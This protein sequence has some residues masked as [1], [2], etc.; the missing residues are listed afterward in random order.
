MKR[1]VSII[2]EEKYFNKFCVKMNRIFGCKEAFSIQGTCMTCPLWIA[3]EAEWGMNEKGMT[4]G[5]AIKAAMREP[6]QKE[7]ARK[8]IGSYMKPKKEY[9]KGERRG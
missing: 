6:I 4:L 1:S 9:P 5:E 3:R 7:E 2:K 8:I